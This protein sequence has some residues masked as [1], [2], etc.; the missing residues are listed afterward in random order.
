[1]IEWMNSRLATKVKQEIPRCPEQMSLRS[2]NGERQKRKLLRL[3]WHR[4]EQARKQMFQQKSKPRLP[5]TM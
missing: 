3:S 5:Q 1:V 4:E 2:S